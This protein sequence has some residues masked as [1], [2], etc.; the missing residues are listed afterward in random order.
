LPS[1][2]KAGRQ[3]LDLPLRHDNFPWLTVATAVGHQAVSKEKPRSQQE[4][5]QQRFFEK[6]IHELAGFQRAPKEETETRK[7]GALRFLLLNYFSG[8]YQIGEV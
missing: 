8:V 7:T 1:L 6:T 5:V 4:E 3:V 2:R